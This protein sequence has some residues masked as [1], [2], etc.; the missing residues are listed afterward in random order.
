MKPLELNERKEYVGTV[1]S[2]QR[3]AFEFQKEIKG[4]FF[5]RIRTYSLGG[6]IFKI[7]NL[8]GK[9]KDA[10]FPI[11]INGE[12]CDLRLLEYITDIEGEKVKYTFK[13]NR[14]YYGTLLGQPMG[15]RNQNYI[16]KILTGKL[17]G[18]RLNFCFSN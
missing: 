14:T 5:T 15:V 17:K 3:K 12:N 11:G 16:L 13:D 18:R 4:T 8:S 2:I 7:K 1:C 9:T 6:F 10:E